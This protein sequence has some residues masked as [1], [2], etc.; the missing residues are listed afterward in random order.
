MCQRRALRAVNLCKSR[1]Q[2]ELEV[3]TDS[4]TIN[5]IQVRFQQGNISITA[6]DV[7]ECEIM[8]QGNMHVRCV[9][10]K[11]ACHVYKVLLELFGGGLKT[12]P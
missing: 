9:Y 3:F 8:L 4:G 10:D 2:Y 6:C 5:S 11:Q 1:Q 7:H 12:S